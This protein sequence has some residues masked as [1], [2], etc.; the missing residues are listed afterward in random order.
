MCH[1]EVYNNIKIDMSLITF[2]PQTLYRMA[3]TEICILNSE[4][5][6]INPLTVTCI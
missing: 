2:C 6:Y 3:G 1:I 4:K 5:N